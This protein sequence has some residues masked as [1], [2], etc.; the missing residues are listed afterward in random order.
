MK[1]SHREI[2]LVLEWGDKLLAA[3]VDSIET[4]EKLSEDLIEN[5][6]E[7]ICSFDNDCIIGIGKRNRGEELVQILDVGKLIEKEDELI[8]ELESEGKSFIE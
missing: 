3:A 4:V 5:M 1:E 8:S 2:A 7:A 6:P